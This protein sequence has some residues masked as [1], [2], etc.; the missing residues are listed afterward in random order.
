MTPAKRLAMALDPALLA[1]ACGVEPDVWQADLLRSDDR[2]VLLNCSRQSGKSTVTA[3][4]AVHTALFRPGLIL[5]L[6]PTQRQSGELFRKV[7]DLLKALGEPTGEESAL[8]LELPSG[9]R[10]VSLPGSQG[11]VRGYSKPELVIVDEAAFVSDELIAAVRPMLAVSRGR[12]VMLS[13]PF[14]Q[15]GA[16][17]DAWEKGGADWRRFKVTAHDCPRIDREWLESERR[18]IGPYIFASEYLCEFLDTV[19]AVFRYEDIQRMV[20][21][22]VKPLFAR[23]SEGRDADPL[24]R[25][26]GRLAP[27]FPRP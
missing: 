6:S 4:L 14:G 12:F 1:R 5:L 3:L 10:V 21:G 22:E 15:R 25:A 17:F 8:R 24:A 27:L 11:T 26:G 2:Q 16:F 7:K 13:T 23:E 19:D 9:A 20:S 18:Q